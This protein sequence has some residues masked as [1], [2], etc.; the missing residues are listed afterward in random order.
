MSDCFIVLPSRLGERAVNRVAGSI[1]NRDG[2]YAMDTARRR[3]A[4][5]FS[6]IKAEAVQEGTYIVRDGIATRVD[7]AL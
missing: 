4:L 7:S 5:A 6:V 1:A 3:A 2:A